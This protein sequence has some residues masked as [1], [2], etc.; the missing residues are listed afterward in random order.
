MI[1]Y[2]RKKGIEH[3]HDYNRKV[4]RYLANLK[5]LGTPNS[6]KVLDC[7]RERSLSGWA[8]ATQVKYLDKMSNILK[9]VDKDFNDLTKEDVL[10]FMEKNVKNNP[11]YSEETKA[12]HIKIFKKFMQWLKGYEDK[13]YPPEVSWLRVGSNNRKRHKNPEDMLNDNDITKLVNVA[14]HPRDK[15]LVMTLAESGCRI[16]ELLT[17]TKKKIC[18]DDK[19]AYFL[20]DGKTGT[21][22]VRVVNSTPYLH[23][24]LDVHPDRDKADAPL[25]T[26]R[27]NMKDIA[28]EIRDGQ[29][30]GIYNL[31]WQYN[32]TY[33]AT[34]Q[35][36]RRLAK[37]AGITKPINPHNFRH[38]RATA[39]GAAGI[40]GVIMN[41]VMGWVQGSKVSATYLHISGKQVDEILL[42]S[43]YGLP[44]NIVA[45]EKPK[46]FPIKCIECG[47]LNQHTAKRCKKCNN[48]I[49]TLTK[50]DIEENSAVI[51]MSKILKQF[52][53]SEDD[54]KAKFIDGIKKEIMEE[55][56][57]VN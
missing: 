39:L 45:E 8:T 10:K 47:E 2:S 54:V 49:G 3:I 20:V 36:L 1:I 18:F 23:D 24:W 35:L 31:E 57:N 48:I 52:V 33:P 46:M 7:Y 16:G 50:D 37:K 26:N 6:N 21:R 27:G 22:R 4:D 41:E 5:K 44:K 43:M 53:G 51:Q 12:T 30:E 40:S 28:K 29:H 25:W 32:L 34:R 19:G 38:S 15:A 11:K 42:P 13:D 55:I 56:K 17:L 9:W 14:E